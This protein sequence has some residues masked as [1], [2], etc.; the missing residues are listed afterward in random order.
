MVTGCLEG[1]AARVSEQPAKLGLIVHQEALPT[2][3]YQVK[4]P[5]SLIAS[6]GL[7][8]TTKLSM[9]RRLDGYST[10]VCQRV[11]RQR[12]GDVPECRAY[13]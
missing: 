1:F 3:D 10:A 13:D 2:I 8:T 5:R 7:N 9:S 4:M 6:A 12:N 11:I